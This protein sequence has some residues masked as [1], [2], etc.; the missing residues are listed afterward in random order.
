M[1]F[2]NPEARLKVGRDMALQFGILSLY[3]FYTCYHYCMYS[4]VF[5][6]TVHHPNLFAYLLLGIYFLHLWIWMS[7]WSSS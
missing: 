1:S 3:C 7:M 4:I 5:T 2:K 6:F